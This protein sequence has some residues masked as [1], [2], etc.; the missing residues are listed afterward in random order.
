MLVWDIFKLR[1]FPTKE[2]LRESSMYLTNEVRFDGFGAQYQSI[3]WTILYAEMNGH[4][5]LYSD[6]PYMENPTEDAAQFLRDAI[7]CMNLR[8]HFSHVTT[9]KEEPIFI[10]KVPSF[11]GIIEKQ[12]EQYHT[13]PT[14]ARLKAL[15][16]ESKVSPFDS[17]HL[18]IAVHIRRPMKFDSRQGGA[19]TPMTYYFY[20]MAAVQQMYLSS[21]KPLLFHIYSQGLTGDFQILQGFPLQLH[22]QD[23]TFETFNGMVFA[24]VLIT[25][26]SSFSYLAGLFSNGRVVYKQFWHAPRHHWYKVN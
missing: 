24:D 17:D 15:Y 23:N 8:P 2:N 5:F 20:V 19:D 6:I 26:A 1:F 4:T 7:E 16:Y 11:F 21:E 9:V 22:L 10:P 3:V 18:H 13:S 25:S 14:F 12:I